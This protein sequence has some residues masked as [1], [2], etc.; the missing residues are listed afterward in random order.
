M[1]QR[2]VCVARPI[3]I[4]GPSCE[5][6][7]PVADGGIIV[8]TTPPGCWGPMIT[9]SLKS[10]HEVTGPVMVEGA[11]VGDAVALKILKIRVLSRASASSADVPVS[12]RFG[13]DPFVDPKCPQ[14]GVVNPETVVRG[15]GKDSIRCKNCGSPANP[16]DPTCGCTMLFDEDRRIGVTVPEQIAQVIASQADAFS[17]MPKESRQHS[18][19]VM[20][21]SD[22]S[23]TVSRLKYMVGNI[24]T[25]PAVDMPSSHNAGDF[26]TL[27]VG[28]EHAFALTEDLLRMRTDGHMDI[29]EVCQ[30]ATVIAPVKVDGAGIYVGDVHALQGDGEIAGHTIDVAAEVTIQV[31]II[32]GVQMDGPVLLPRPQDLPDIVRPLSFDETM[33]ARN[34]AAGLDFSI[35]ED[36]LPIQVVGTGANLNAAVDNG[37]GRAADLLNMSIEEVKV[38]ST[39]TGC[40]EI[41]RLPGV[42]GITM[43]APIAALRRRGLA[44]AVQEQYQATQ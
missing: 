38:R 24:G 11:R 15:T 30:G 29:N 27:L 12:G 7:G 40:V 22:V 23:G 31:K 9:P 5:G 32:P 43:L 4:V 17:A 25:I 6:L 14:C 2:A 39:I 13:S 21:L 42:V 1:A 8:A 10:G 36:A 35:D 37:L 34:L 16:F 28:A 18:V 41:G 33:I 20:G 44:A 3:D 19:N 26:A